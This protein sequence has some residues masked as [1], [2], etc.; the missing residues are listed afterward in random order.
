MALNTI[1]ENKRRENRYNWKHYLEKYKQK[2]RFGI[3]KE[4]TYNQK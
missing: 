1:L 3:Y 4:N 2:A